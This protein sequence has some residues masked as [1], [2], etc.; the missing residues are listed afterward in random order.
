[1]PSGQPVPVTAMTPYDDQSI[2]VVATRVTRA[3]TAPSLRRRP[4]SIFSDEYT[5]L[6]LSE[7]TLFPTPVDARPA[8]VPFQ[9]SDEQCACPQACPRA[10]RAPAPAYARRCQHLPP[11][12]RVWVPHAAD[13]QRAGT[14]VR[15]V[16]P[17][18]LGLR[19]GRIQLLLLLL[20]RLHLHRDAGGERASTEASGAPR[21]TRAP[22]TARHLPKDAARTLT[23]SLLGRMVSIGSHLPQPT[24]STSNCRCGHLRVLWT[25]CILSTLRLRTLCTLC[26]PCPTVPYHTCP[27][28]HPDPPPFAQDGRTQLVRH[29]CTCRPARPTLPVTSL[30]R[31]H[32]T[33]TT[34]VARIQPPALPTPPPPATPV[35][36]PP[37][38]R[39]A[40]PVPAPLTTPPSRPRRALSFE[41]RGCRPQAP[42]QVQRGGASDQGLRA[43][44]AHGRRRGWALTSQYSVLSTQCSLLTTTTRDSLLTTHYSLDSPL[45]T[46]HNSTLLPAHHA[47]PTT[48]RSSTSTPA[49]LRTRSRPSLA[50]AGARW[51]K[52]RRRPRVDSRPTPSY[53]PAPPPRPRSL[54]SGPAA[55]STQSA[56]PR[57]LAPRSPF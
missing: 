9:L 51:L 24:P 19:A 16:P 17:P 26:A 6:T 54:S 52:A 31:R 29:Y 47:L 34:R 41:P 10:S 44:R 13:Q 49:P 56:L 15:F 36:R 11:P 38:L 40:H 2:P 8:F 7:H 53:H 57:P 25:L 27:S 12:E 55:P 48:A 18:R 23:P 20:R 46:H 3:M 5:S 22:K 42:H 4:S 32:V 30:A 14:Q 1:M 45:A 35:P 33:H 39:S 21:H 50:S 43:L 37:R 28:P